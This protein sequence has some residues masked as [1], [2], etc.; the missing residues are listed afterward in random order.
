VYD[1]SLGREIDPNEAGGAYED[2][3]RH[4]ISVSLLANMQQPD[5][6]SLYL[7]TETVRS[8]RASLPHYPE[9]ALFDLYV[10]PPRDFVQLL[11][12]YGYVADPKKA[13]YWLLASYLGDVSEKVL[14]MAFTRIGLSV[15]QAVGRG[16]LIDRLST[17]NLD[18]IGY[19]S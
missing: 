19:Y 15:A 2:D 12:E 10:D 1:V 8:V 5:P 17:Y 9:T 6:Y 4:S 11:L 16:D 3:L 7:T 18:Q 13:P 14:R